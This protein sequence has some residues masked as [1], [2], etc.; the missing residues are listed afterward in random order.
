MVGGFSSIHAVRSATNL[1]LCSRCLIVV[2]QSSGI[3]IMESQIRVCENIKTISFN[4]FYVPNKSALPEKL[5][6][7]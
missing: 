2:T 7:D 4:V 5:R 3:T 6:M 1:Q